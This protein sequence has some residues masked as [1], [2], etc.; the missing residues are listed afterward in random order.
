LTSSRL[1]I[2]YID[3][4]ILI[5]RITPEQNSPELTQQIESVRGR[6]F[7]FLTSELTRLEVSRFLHR[8]K[9]YNTNS[10]VFEQQNQNVLAG[11]QL[12]RLNSSTLERAASFP[13]TH[14]GSLDSIHLASAQIVSATHFLTRDRQLINACAELGIATT[15]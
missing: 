7:A 1:K 12:I 3:T 11:I 13:F 8:V 14:L 6:D 9:D 4:N 2:C 10:V 5:S 15:F